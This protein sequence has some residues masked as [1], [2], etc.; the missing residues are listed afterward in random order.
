[1]TER[2][3]PEELFELLGRHV[4]SWP[5]EKVQSH[6][7]E[8]LF[9]D[10]ARLNKDRRFHGRRVLVARHLLGDQCAH[11]E[12]PVIVMKGLEVAMLYPRPIERPFR[13]LDVLVANPQERW[14]RLIAQGCRHNP[15]REGIDDHHHLPALADPTGTLGIELHRRPNVPG[16]AKVPSELV[17]ETAQP[18]RTGIDGVL[19]PRDDVHALLLTMHCWKSG[20]TRLRD[21][22]DATLLA[23]TSDHDAEETARSLGLR[24]VWNLSMRLA[25]ST[26][27]GV[28]SR[29]SGLERWMTPR[30]PGVKDRR[31]IRLMSPYLAVNPVTVTVSH[32]RDVLFSRRA[33]RVLSA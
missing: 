18:S 4:G 11:H 24:R 14:D 3:A 2:R 25:D 16:W 12:G 28:E 30:S 20:F 26:L 10:E 8:L 19:R 7:F 27:F 9:G 33:R 6:G 22:F 31:R 15:Q 1:V 23:A 32:A 17:F 21:L 29:A 13:D 5:Y